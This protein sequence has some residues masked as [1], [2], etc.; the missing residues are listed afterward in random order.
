M[1]KLWNQ[2]SYAIILVVLS[3]LTSF[4]L[5]VHN[6]VSGED[7]LMKI[8]V[9][10]GD[11]LWQLAEDF[12]D[13]HMLSAKEF[14][15]WVERHNGISGDRIYPGDELVLPIALEKGNGTQVASS[16]SK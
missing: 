9:N 5:I 16:Q 1:K 10:E 11:S 3:L 15:E 13:E 7:G 8:T 6:G 14:V 4:I 2:Y 12:S